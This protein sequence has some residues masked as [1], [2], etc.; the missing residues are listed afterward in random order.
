[1]PAYGRSVSKL[2]RQLEEKGLTVSEDI[3]Q[4]A[5]SLDKCYVPTR[6]PNAW[7]EGAPHDYYRKLDASQ[8]ADQAQ[9]I[10]SWVDKIWR[11][12][13]KG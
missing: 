2:L 11:Q 8:A 5:K 1:M 3:V 6:Y 4:A 9:Q 13:K 10:L 7:S 12:L